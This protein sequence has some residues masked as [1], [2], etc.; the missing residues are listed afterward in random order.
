MKTLLLLRHAKSSWKDAMLPDHDRPLNQRGKAEAPRVGQWLKHHDLTPDLIIAS[1]AKRAR[2]TAKR[3]AEA[4][5]YEGELELNEALYEGD[6]EDYLAALRAAPDGC[7]HVLLVGHNPGVELFLEQLTDSDDLM[8]T[9]ALAHITL[10]ITRW[11]QLTPRTKGVLADL[12]RPR[13]EA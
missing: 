9:A 7:A 12:W 11:A 10:P 6:P 5:G 2:A 8:P 4:C 1:T 13:D 3:V